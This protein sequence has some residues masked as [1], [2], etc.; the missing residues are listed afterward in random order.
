MTFFKPPGRQSDRDAAAFMGF[1]AGSDDANRDPFMAG[2][3]AFW[4]TKPRRCPLAIA[5]T[6][7]TDKWLSGWD[8][9]ALEA[10]RV[11]RQTRAVQA[12]AKTIRDTLDEAGLLFRR[13]DRDWMRKPPGLKGQLAAVRV[14]INNCLMHIPQLDASPAPET[15]A[16]EGGTDASG[17]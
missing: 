14:A 6:I 10:S 15:S 3:Q 4:G 16:P 17:V 5:D 9:A 7:G 2:Q 8:A 12:Y 1:S 11:L 13:I